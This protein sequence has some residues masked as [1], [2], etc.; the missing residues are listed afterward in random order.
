MAP[1]LTAS[2]MLLVG[3][4]HFTRTSMRVP[5]LDHGGW[6]AIEATGISGVE[7]Q[8]WKGTSRLVRYPLVPGHEVVG[9]IADDPHGSFGLPIGTRVVVESSIRCG[10][11]HRCQA[12]LSSCA[13]RKPTNA[14][15]QVPSTEA[16]GLWGGLAEY[17]FLDPSARLH[18]VTDDVPAA[19]GS[20]AHALAAGFTWAVETPQLR[21]GQSVLILGPG[22]RGLA[23]LIAAQAAGAGWVGMTGLS[24][25]ADRLGLAKELGADLVV[26]VETEDLASAVG[27]S[28][29]TRPD[30]IVDVTSNDSEVILSALDLVRP[31]GVVV[32]AST[33]G[34]NAINQ[35]FSDIIVLKELCLRGAFGASSTAY[36]WATRQI[37]TDDRLDELVSHEFPLDEADRAIQASDGMLGRDQLFSVAVTL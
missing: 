34:T 16:P 4:R 1:P 6:L 37:G 30:V 24:H 5:E 22:P 17:L 3:P 13:G 12:G 20:F 27:N 29:G 35:L 7:V 32:L 19:V 36:H 10:R 25:D 2:A 15:G 9:R 11:C 26:D 31:G 23:S 14:Y 28:L 8:A 18:A 21:P 33:K